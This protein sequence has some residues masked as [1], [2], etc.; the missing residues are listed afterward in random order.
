MGAI[1]GAGARR[2]DDPGD[3][4]TPCVIRVVRVSGTIRKSEEEL[5]RRARAEIVR[6]KREGTSP[7]TEQGERVLEGL[8]GEKRTG[9]DN[10]RGTAQGASLLVGGEEEVGIEDLDDDDEDDMEDLSD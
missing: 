5:L 7:G 3:R 1:P 4:Q 8:F 6:A 2:G 10:R 9:K